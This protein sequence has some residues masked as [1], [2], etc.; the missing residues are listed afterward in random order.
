MLC[1]NPADLQLP[2][3]L[4]IRQ[5]FDIPP[6]IDPATAL[7]GEFAAIKH[8]LSLR[9]GAKVAVGVGSRGISGL[10]T[11]VAGVVRCLRSLGAEPFIIPA[12]GSHG[13]ATAQ[14]QIEVLAHR[15]VTEET[16]GAPIRA[17]MEVISLGET[18]C[19]IPLFVNR[20][21]QEADGLVLINRVKPH[22]NF[23]GPTESGILK[24]MS[25]GLGNQAGAE[26]YH[27]LSLVRPQYE[28]LST[29]GREAMGRS[30]FLFGVALV[31]NQ[32][33]ELC[34]LRLAGPEHMEQVETELMGLAR[35]ILPRLPMERVDLLIVEE[36]GKEIS[37]MGIDPNV[38][39][40]D[41][42]A[43][44]AR[45]ESPKIARIHVRRLSE[46]TAGSAVGIGQADSTLRG[47]VDEIDQQVTI[48]NCL[49]ACAPEAGMIP[50][51]YD[52]DLDAVAAALMTIRPYTLDDLG[53]V[54]I[55]NTM[56]LEE[57]YASQAFYAALE[58]DPKVKIASKGLS[59]EFDQGMLRSPF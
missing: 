53:I 23:I 43:Y 27:R 32:N 22:T 5:I 20:L 54:Y 10:A 8:G 9:P 47:L 1:D 46:H 29:A 58:A 40:R 3:M 41:V 31:E 57:L 49:T 13:G 42:A 6:A 38:V 35:A 18:S 51:T 14:G 39:G 56:E 48:I 30:N 44:G 33:H 25:I 45:R 7:E 4:K 16:C 17:T 55:K 12:M 59:L 2:P 34:N 28:I 21:A 50:P 19:G 36:M 11:V 52:T 37:G 15:G 24:M 26:Y